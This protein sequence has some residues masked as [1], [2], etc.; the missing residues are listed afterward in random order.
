M[1]SALGDTLPAPSIRSVLLLSAITLWSRSPIRKE[2]TAGIIRL[3][4][5]LDWGSI[6]KIRDEVSM[7][8]LVWKN[9]KFPQIRFIDSTIDTFKFG[10]MPVIFFF[11]QMAV[12]FVRRNLEMLLLFIITTKL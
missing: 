4:Q 7:S 3:Y 1:F 5:Q 9:R 11:P 10:L 12:N 8:P 6:S 2:R